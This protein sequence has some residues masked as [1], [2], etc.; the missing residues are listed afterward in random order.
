MMDFLRRNVAWL[1]IALLI[2]LGANL[3]VGGA[4]AGR[5]FHHR[6]GPPDRFGPPPIEAMN[7]PGQ[8]RWLL[9]RIAGDLP[10]NERDAFRQAMESRRDALIARSKDLRDAR[11]AVR[12]TIE[13]RPFD[14]A[15]YNT[16]VA[17]LGE[18]QNA[19]AD[20]LANAIGDALEL[21]AGSPPAPAGSGST[22]Q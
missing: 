8:V 22:G 21:A 4:F 14:R 17:A 19:F 3:F 18:R 1:A 10:G 15:A 6:F 9:R 20:E 11:D 5:F 2:S 7:G 13:T 16:A 12:S